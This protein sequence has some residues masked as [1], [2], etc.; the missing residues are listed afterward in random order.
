MLYDKWWKSPGDTCMRTE[1]G[2]ESKANSLGV[3]NIG[4][5]FVV[6]L[7]GLAFA[8]LIAI[9][10]FCYNTRR[11]MP[12]ERRAPISTPACSDSLQG[13]SQSVQQ[14]QQTQQQQQQQQLQQQA[15]QQQE[16]L[17]SEMARELCR[18][19]RCHASSRRRR[20]CEKCSTHVLGYPPDNPTATPL[21][22]MRS[23]RSS[24]GVPTVELPPNVHMHHHAPPPHDYDGT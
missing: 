18:A 22:G 7:C 16:S 12:A 19:L 24:L 3:D 11:N 8:V 15:N 13:I 2:K 6:L 5:V 4:G 1:K 21:N 20:A 9:F 14:Q 23:Q 10:E 17:C